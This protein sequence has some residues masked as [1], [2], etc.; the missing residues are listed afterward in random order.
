MINTK[1][2]PKRPG[3]NNYQSTPASL[4]GQFG[5]DILTICTSDFNQ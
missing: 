4:T 2:G 3:N 5:H 1:L